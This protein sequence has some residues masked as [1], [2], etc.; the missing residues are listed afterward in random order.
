MKRS[1]SLTS[2]CLALLLILT[3]CGSSGGS[4]GSGAPGGASNS[5]SGPNALSSVAS[6]DYSEEYYDSSAD[7]GA[8]D[9]S[10]EVE[11]ENME[12]I[13]R[14]I[15]NARMDLETD[16]AREL[17]LRLREYS[18]SLG[19][20][21]YS[22]Q[23]SNREEYSSIYATLKLP[24]ER[25]N[26]FMR[27]AEEQGKLINSSVGS[28]D[29][30][31]SYYDTQTRLETKRKSLDRYYA[32]LE[33]ADAVDEII[34]IRQ[35]IDSITED[36]ESLEGRLRVWNS[37]TTMATVTLSIR[38]ENDPILTRREIS[39]NTLTADDMAYLIKNGFVSVS[40]TIVSLAQWLVIA[41][42][43]F[44]PL[45]VIAVVLLLIVRRIR[46][47]RPVSDV[48]RVPFWKR[49]G[50]QVRGVNPF[51]K[52]QSGEEPESDDKKE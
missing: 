45:I 4:G 37:L 19:G 12:N 14:V 7:Y 20:Y 48:A 50:S 42:I 2:V 16:N 43:A 36:I 11:P 39:W 46:K 28:E 33:Q 1:L 24:P 52:K 10:S 21:E 17:Y 23:L 49:R 32:L 15:Q 18:D 6:R 38:Q 30:T 35:T 31:D 44:S 29:I 22:C 26:D 8:Y 34:A 13:R 47:N 9:D 25:L 3:A 27:F 41:A 5:N 51:A 40:N